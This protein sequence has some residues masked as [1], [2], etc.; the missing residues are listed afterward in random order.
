MK[1]FGIVL[2]RSITNDVTPKDAME[3]ARHKSEHLF[4]LVTYMLKESNN[5]Y[6][7][8]LTKE[9]GYSQ[10]GEATYKQGVYAI[11]KIITAHTKLNMEKA[12]LSDGMGTRYNLIS[13][14]HLVDLLSAVY[15]DEA[16]RPLIMTALPEAGRSGSLQDR[17]KKTSLEGKIHAKTGSMHDIS[18]LSGYLFVD[19]K[20]PLIFS[21][22]INGIDK[23]LSHA[24]ALEEEILM[25]VYQAQRY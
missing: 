20:H 3:I 24:K 8:T 11:K 10:T 22:I 16:I 9:L 13:V 19:N 23:P 21:I 5:L 17:M 25:A 4:E 6:A 18:S 12:D 7:N 15:R 14:K 1:K 2:K